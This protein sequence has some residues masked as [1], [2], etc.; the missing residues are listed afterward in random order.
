ML[1]LLLAVAVVIAIVALA[2]WLGRAPPA[3]RAK[4]LQQILL[5]GGGAILLVLAIA[6]RNPLVALLGVALPWFQRAMMA[7]GLWNK[8]QSMRRP[9]SGQTSRVETAVLR[10]TLDHDSGDLGGEVIS[11]S[12]SAST[13]ADLGLEQLIDLLRGLRDNDAQ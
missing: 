2:R 12:F 9:S 8:F 1:R 6:F 11:G 7:R 4:A 5:F 13:L 3:K 10:M